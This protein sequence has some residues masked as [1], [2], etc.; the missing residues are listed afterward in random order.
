MTRFAALRALLHPVGLLALVVAVVP[1]FA[2]SDSA[3][4]SALITDPSGA[5]VTNASVTLVNTD[6]NVSQTTLSNQSRPQSQWAADLGE[7]L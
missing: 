4:L 3:T 7:W 2:Q 6:T 1:V 5:V